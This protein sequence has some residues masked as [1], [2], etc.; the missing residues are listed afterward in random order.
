MQNRKKLNA[1]FKR[2]FRKDANLQERQ[3]F[4]RWFSSLDLSNGQ[5]FSNP[6]E[7]LQIKDKME[8]HLHSHFF[9]VEQQTRIRKLPTWFPLATAAMLTIVAGTIWLIG[10]PK[11]EQQLILEET[12]TRAAER[13]II[14]LGDGSVIT[15]NN[16]S[17]IK[18][19]KV[20]SDTL[21]EVYLEGEAFFDVAKNKYKPFVVKTGKLSIKVLGTSFN[22]KHYSA[23]QNINVVVATG[24]VGV[25]AAGQHQT[26]LLTPGHQL[27][28][29]KLNASA[30]QNLV[31]PADYIAW[32]RSELIFKDERLEDICKR[33]ERWYDVKI[34]IRNAQLK[35]KRISLKQKNESLSTVLK[36]LGIV[37]D[38]KHQINGRAVEIW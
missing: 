14:T 31:D 11:K 20:F 23:D 30:V 3:L 10:M 18:Y 24:K 7:E 38:F 28:Y 27:L 26:W 2:L 32:Q 15:L 8:Q 33:L 1:S 5:I 29:D 22:I 21:R 4:A 12:I 9:P 36:M 34:T 35:N 37:G 17:R 16:D 25:K 13:K 19:P 6:Q